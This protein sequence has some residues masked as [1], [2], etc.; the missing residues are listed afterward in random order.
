MSFFS[1]S[2][3]ISLPEPRGK[4]CLNLSA[5]PCSYK[6]C[7]NVHKSTVHIVEPNSTQPTDARITFPVTLISPIY[8][9]GY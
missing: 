4:S 3:E 2:L 1:F 9:L 7:Y 6:V 8:L 5:Q